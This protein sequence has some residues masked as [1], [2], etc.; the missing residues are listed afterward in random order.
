MNKFLNA[1]IQ[2]GIIFLML[3]DLKFLQICRKKIEPEIFISS[4]QQRIC[5]I[6]FS[7][8]DKYNAVIN[9]DTS[10]IILTEFQE[11]EQT[12]VAIYLNKLFS[13]IYI[14]DYILDKLNLFLNK[15]SWELALI[16]CVEYLDKDDIEGIKKEIKNALSKEIGHNDIKNIFDEDLKEFYN[17]K[18]QGEICCPTGI[19]ALDSLIGGIKYKELT[20]VVAPLNVGKSFFFIFLGSKALL[21]SKTVLYITNEMSKQQVKGRFFQRFAGVTDKPMGEIEIWSDNQRIKHESDNLLNAKKV[22]KSIDT[23]QSFGGKLYI[24]EFPDKTLTINKLESL[25]NDIEIVEGKCPELLLV[26]SLQGLKYSISGKADWKDLENLSHEL[27]R[28]AM[29]KNIAIVTSTHSGRSSIGN[30]LVQAKDV[31]GSIDI[32]NIAD[33]GVSLNQTN[34]EYLL[35]QMRIFVMRSRSSKKWGQVKIHTNFDMGHFCVFS[36]LME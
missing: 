19:K 17:N 4:I 24:A 14:K 11:E 15:R 20:L 33:L 28:I 1:S 26:D 2:D 30:K 36:E 7:F 25:L 35:N 5:K 3:I 9:A 32:L 16:Q 13:E 23:M 22:K 6:I 29:E 21:Y 31:R 34:E 27:R 12:S 8:F 18:Y 10:E